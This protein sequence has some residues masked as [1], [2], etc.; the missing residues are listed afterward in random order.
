MTTL[1]VSIA[2]F[3]EMLSGLIK[4]GVTFESEEREG[5]ILITFLG[6]Y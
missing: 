6:G 2:T 4:S 3:T 5:G 1:F